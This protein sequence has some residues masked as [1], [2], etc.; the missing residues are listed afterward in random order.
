MFGVTTSMRDLDVIKQYLIEDTGKIERILESIECQ[1]IKYEQGGSLIVCQLPP[2]FNSNNKR[3]CQV[4]VIKGLPC[5]IRNRNDFD[6]DIFDLVSYIHFDKRGEEIKKNLHVAKQYICELFGW[7]QFITHKKGVIVKKDYASPLKNIIRKYERQR[8]E[9]KTNPVLPESILD[10]YLPYPSYDWW[11][12]GISYKVQKMYDIRFDLESKRIIIPM[13]NRFGQLIGVKGRILKDEDDDR[14]YLYLY[15]FQNRYE[16]FNFH[17]AY[18]YIL[19]EKKVFIFEAEKS[20]MKMATHGIF[21]TL[22]IGS[23]DISPEQVEI[24]KQLGLDIAIILCYDSDKTPEE[25]YEQAKK[26]K[27]RHVYATYDTLGLL[28]E[29]DSPIDRGIDVFN[30]L[31]GNCCFE[32]K[33]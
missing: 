9:I 18:P 4:R 26:F 15:P 33:V 24:I 23:S 13:R 10:Q 3:A 21:N 25:I 19:S 16:W 12:E 7:E 2:K 17:I 30:K 6:G 29:K 22:S 28:G 14:K 11:K 20:C 5:Y 31:L 1:N 8:V 27:N 32:V